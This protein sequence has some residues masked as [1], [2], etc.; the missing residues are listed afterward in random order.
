[1]ILKKIKDPKSKAYKEVVDLGDS[2]SRTLGFLPESAF[3]K[4]ASDGQ[5][6]A[7]YSRDSKDLLG[8]ILYRV[9]YN[10]VTI[11]HLC[12]AKES[13]G[14]KVALA[15]VNELKSSTTQ[16]DGIRLSC[17]NDYGIDHVW[18]S[19]NFVPMKERIGR[20][21]KKLPLTVWWYPHHHEDLL[22]QISEYE[23]KNKV[24]A[25]IDM[26][27][28]LDIKDG[29]EE[30]S[31]ALKSDWLLS[32]AILYY[33]R[34]IHNE[35]N[36]G[37]TSEIKK[38]SRKLLN[39]FRVLPFKAEQEFKEVLKELKNQFPAKSKNDKSDLRHLAYSI[40]GGA[41][42][43]ITRDEEL[44]ASKDYF[45]KFELQ[46]S[47]PSE[48]ITH[49]DEN[50]QV[51]KY[52]PQRLIGTNIDSKRVNSENIDFFTNKFLK[53]NEKKNQFQK[54]IRKALS[55]PKQFELITISA[56]EEVLALIIFDRSV[57]KK[58]S[59]PVFRFLKSSLKITLS[60]HLLF[61]AI[62]TSTNESRTLIEISEPFLEEEILNSIKE[63]RFIKDG[64]VWKKFNYKKI[65]DF[66]QI[67]S[68]ISKEYIKKI[69]ENMELQE[70][71][72]NYDF[73][74]RY[75]L[76]RHLSPI[77]IKDFDIPTYVIPIKPVWAEQLF[78]DRSNEKLH[79]FEAENELLLNR[80]NVYYR[81]ASKRSLK[82]PARI[83][84]YISENPV[85]KE[86]GHI[87][88]A[89]YID[90]IFVDDAKKLFRQFEQLG[91]YKWRDISR[92]ADSKSKIMAFI[93][94]DTEL[95]KKPV[96]LKFLRELFELKED[97]NFMVLSPVKIKPE[98][99]LAIYKRGME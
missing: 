23:L 74:K 53:P 58:L 87:K 69:E 31:L 61:K 20:S 12:V 72:D 32:E 56:S 34:E 42:F 28:F 25:V 63:A 64:D 73:L 40:I 39:Y 44:L 10:R 49:L 47:R 78:D 8:Y 86:K 98:M 35:I 52:K 55:S 92:T 59:I 38:S 70:E 71:D 26:N 94:S 37:A 45:K 81:S 13:R 51:S 17:R 9:S 90:E 33:T 85:T 21:S 77:K 91:I 80:E 19:F 65:V 36:R 96:D 29:R 89:S 79:L 99:Y 7:A 18:E 66:I 46:I 11:V 41:Q 62:L 93:F 48:F 60:K 57:D 22:S 43:F 88:A 3:A 82:A 95:F 30:E 54:T 83:L 75:N 68:L 24:V 4:Y 76:E 67:E 50:I 6:I 2:N 5:L 16:F 84:W 15:L 14:S 27:V 97:K 1:M